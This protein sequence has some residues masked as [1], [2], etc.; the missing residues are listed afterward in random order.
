MTEEVFKNEP[1]THQPR[2]TPHPCHVAESVTKI[3]KSWGLSETTLNFFVTLA[4]TNRLD[5][6]AG[7]IS[8]FEVGVHL[9]S[10]KLVCS[11]GMAC[12]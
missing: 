6:T 5:K 12:S 11:C 3:S 1:A 4:Q 7:I 9:M 8:A 2:S 10:R